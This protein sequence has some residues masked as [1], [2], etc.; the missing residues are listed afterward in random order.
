MKERVLGDDPLI[1]S[2][3]FLLMIRKI[4]FHLLLLTKINHFIQR[5]L[6]IN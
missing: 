2:L 4:M 3:S 5:I 1:L 6:F